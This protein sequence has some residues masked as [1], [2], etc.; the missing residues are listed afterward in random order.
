MPGLAVSDVVSVQVSLNP[1]ASALRNF[2]ALLILG[3]SSVI[4]T[5][6]RIR[7][8]YGVFK[9]ITIPW[10]KGNQQILS[11]CQFTQIC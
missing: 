3:D 1:I 10:H 6:T 7:N 9:V 11:E 4:D 5:Q 8:K 2:G